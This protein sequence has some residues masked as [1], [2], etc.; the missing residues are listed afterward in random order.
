MKFNQLRIAVMIAVLTLFMGWIITKEMRICEIV[1][2]RCQV[3]GYEF[4][5]SSNRSSEARLF[6]LETV[7]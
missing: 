2:S 5:F 1:D 3:S 6:T 7:S 4:A